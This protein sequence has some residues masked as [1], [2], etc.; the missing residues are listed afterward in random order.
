MKQVPHYGP[1]NI[2]RQGTRWSRPGDPAPGGFCTTAILDQKI[3]EIR[4]RSFR[5]SLPC[6]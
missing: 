6:I 1:T 2:R 5:T 4:S 3:V